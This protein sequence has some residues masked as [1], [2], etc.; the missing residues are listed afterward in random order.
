MKYILP[1]LL[2]CTLQLCAQG[3]AQKI[4]IKGIIT[5][6]VDHSPLGF[7]TVVLLDSYNDKPVQSVLSKDNGTFELIGTLGQQ[8]K[9]RLNYV[10]YTPKELN[11]PLASS[12]PA[13][14]LGIII[15]ARLGGQLKEVSIIAAKPYLKQEIDRLSYDVQAD[16][17]NKTNDA[18]EMLRKVPMVSI[19]ASDNIKLNGSDSYQIFINGKPSAL[20]ASD[21]ADVLKVIPAATILKIEVITTPPAKYDAEGLSGIINIITVQKKDDGFNG[22]VFG[23]YNNTWGERG[24]FTAAAKEGKL[25]VN[26]FFGLGHQGMVNTEAGSQIVSSTDLVQQGYN[27]NGGNFRNG[28]LGLN[29]E[30]DSLNLLTATMDFNHRNFDQNEYR[31]SQLFG[32]ADSLLQQYQLADIGNNIWDMFD[33]GLNYQL[34]FKPQKVRAA[35]TISIFPPWVFCHYANTM[36]PLESDGCV[37]SD[38]MYAYHCLNPE[39]I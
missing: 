13:L 17:E 14:N 9:I 2:F 1:F 11:V 7:A 6:S 3:Q 22:S 34:G 16:P 28:N 5:D 4:N 27:L 8:Y 39:I 12:K 10:G 31:T 35:A 20:M 21:P 38:S 29:Y 32:G 36:V 30:A 24:S 15:L 19:D 37:S 23:R 18:F 25:G 33:L 26:A